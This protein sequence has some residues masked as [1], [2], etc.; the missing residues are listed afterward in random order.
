MAS[1]MSCSSRKRPGRFAAPIARTRHEAN[2]QDNTFLSCFPWFAFPRFASLRL[3]N[4]PHQ[5]V[6]SI[7]HPNACLRGCFHKR[8]RERSRK[9]LTFF[10]GYRT[11]GVQ[12]ELVAD[13]H[14]WNLLCILHSKD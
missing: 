2:S 7:L 5:F 1:M 14:H 8:A 9:L 6:E 12:V 11:L 13:N 3:S 4:L 10:R